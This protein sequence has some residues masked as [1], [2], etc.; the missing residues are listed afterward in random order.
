[1]RQYPRDP[2]REVTLSYAVDRINGII[3]PPSRQSSHHCTTDCL[4]MRPY[5]LP[6]TALISV[7]SFSPVPM[8]RRRNAMSRIMCHVSNPHILQHPA[9][10]SPARIPLNPI[11]AVAPD[12]EIL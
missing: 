5:R 7:E 1:M 9:L 4:S 2:N 12:H 8:G 10:F 6:S 3:M 11:N